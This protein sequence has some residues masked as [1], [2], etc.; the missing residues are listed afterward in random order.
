MALPP[1]FG[2]HRLHHHLY[3]DGDVER[4][5]RHAGRTTGVDAPLCNN[6][7]RNAEA[8]SIIRY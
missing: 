1:L 6:D 5:F 7:N 3:L 2:F 4:E 8:P